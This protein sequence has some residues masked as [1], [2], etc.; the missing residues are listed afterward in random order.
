MYSTTQQAKDSLYGNMFIY[1]VRT[2]IVPLSLDL[3][4]GV[5][6]KFGIKL[7]DLNAYNIA[8]DLKLTQWSSKNFLPKQSFPLYST[9][10][11]IIIL[12]RANAATS[13]W[14]TVMCR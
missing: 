10:I 4:N 9:I 14:L 11:I 5:V 13:F 3:W 8:L 12:P 2:W 7:G 6:I 1:V